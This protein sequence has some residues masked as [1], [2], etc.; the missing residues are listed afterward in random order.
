MLFR[1]DLAASINTA[2][3]LAGL[4]VGLVAYSVYLFTLRGFYAHQDTRTPFLINCVQNLLNIALA[5]ALVGRFQV[6]GLGIAFA[7]SYVVAAVVALFVLQIK[8]PSFPVLHTMRSLARMLA[9]GAVMGIVVWLATRA[10]GADSGGGA[11]LKL[12]A[13]TVIGAIVYVGALTVLRVPEVASLRS[14]ATRFRNR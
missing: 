7:A 1:S 8:V 10:V 3:V 4:S 12:A 2:R 9:A 11:L 5:F 14:I 13:G 6:L